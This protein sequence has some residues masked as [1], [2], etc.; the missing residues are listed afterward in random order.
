MKVHIY[1][2]S[3]RCNS[4]MNSIYLLLTSNVLLELL[5]KSGVLA[6]FL[7]AVKTVDSYSALWLE[8]PYSSGI[9]TVWFLL[10]SKSIV[11]ADISNKPAKTAPSTISYS[12]ACSKSWL[13]TQHSQFLS[14]SSLMTLLPMGIWMNILACIQT[15]CFSWDVWV[16]MHIS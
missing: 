8:V 12:T 2:K 11:T 10:Y 5:P 14:I 4:L 16:G 6:S 3:G 9:S 1:L 15:S 7:T 13:E